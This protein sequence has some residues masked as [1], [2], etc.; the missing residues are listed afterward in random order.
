MYHV[1]FVIY[2]F[3]IYSLTLI[4]INEDIIDI[5]LLSL[6]EVHEAPARLNFL[7][8]ITQIFAK[9]LCVYSAN[10]FVYVTANILSVEVNNTGLLNVRRFHS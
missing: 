4:H 9:N 8:Q 1:L 2:S 3:E 5:H 7:S 6:R 10:M